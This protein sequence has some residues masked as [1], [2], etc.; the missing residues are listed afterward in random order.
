MDSAPDPASPCDLFPAT[1]TARLDYET[2]PHAL[3]RR[4][5][6]AR[7]RPRRAWLCRA[8]A[9]PARRRRGRPEPDRPNAD[10]L[11][12]AQTGS[13]KT[14]AFGLALASTLL[15]D[16]E[17]LRPRRP[18]RCALIIAPTR[19]LAMQISREF[20]WLY[21]DT[22]ARIV[23]VRR[24][25]ERAR[26]AAAALAR[27]PHRHRH[28]GPP[29]RPPHQGLS[30]PLRAAGRRARRSR[31]DAR[32]RLPRRTRNAARRDQRRDPP[33]APVLGH[34]RARHRHARQ[35]LP[36]RRG[37]HRHHQRHR[38]ARRHR[39]PRHARLA[40]RHRTRRRQRAAL[41][42]SR[43]APSSSAPRAKPCAT[44]T[45][46]CASAASTPSASPAK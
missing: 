22:G 35:E 42:R 20:E 25:H 44:S 38:T 24:R 33:H 34:H 29:L 27:R 12:S 23:A 4:P 41:F 40:R 1:G 2:T 9:R 45:P 14:V 7:P 6:R 30:R 15:G 46:P 8:D 43:P 21:A 16:A 28:A 32:P 18:R 36:A 19:E 39:L 11:V 5:S 3:P 37:P 31:R 10:L 17:T 26:R 13:G